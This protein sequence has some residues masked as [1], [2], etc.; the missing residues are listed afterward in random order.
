MSV[1]L[2]GEISAIAIAML[3][4]FAIVT[5]ILAYLAFRKQSREVRAIERQVTDEQELTRQ[6]GS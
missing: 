5:A 3:A 2:S 6:Q 1:V 4:L